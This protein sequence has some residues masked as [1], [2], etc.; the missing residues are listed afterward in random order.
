MFGWLAFLTLFTLPREATA[1]IDL[2]VEGGVSIA[3]GSGGSGQETIPTRSINMLSL[4]LFPSV[5]AGLALPFGNLELRGGILGE[6][7]FVGQIPDPA[8]YPTSDFGPGTEL[9]GNGSLIGVGTELLFRK[10]SLLGS[11]D[12]I[13]WH[14]ATMPAPRGSGGSGTDIHFASVHGYRINLGYEI[15]TKFILEVTFH[16]TAFWTRSIGGIDS[17]G[18]EDSLNFSTIG[19]GTRIAY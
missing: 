7:R 16:H 15:L 5:G 8:N 19:I 18:S 1:S 13:G 2:G 6:Y 4:Q 14:N 9:R 3:Y 11:L 17:G 10:F 12:F